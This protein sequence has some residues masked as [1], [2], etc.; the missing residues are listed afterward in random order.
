MS[1]TKI[2]DS[3]IADLKVS[4][5]PTRPTA[6]TAFGGRG[7]TASEMKAAFDR[8]PLYIIERLNELWD[9]IS[10]ESPTES[11]AD[12]IYTNIKYGHTLR[13]LFNDITSGECSRYLRVNGNKLSAELSNMT[14]RISDITERLTAVEKPL[15]NVALDA[16]RPY[17][18]KGEE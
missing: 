2:S 6:P 11:V 4:A 16:G 5:L 10:S 1:F 12:D 8:L 18:P 7:Y 3:E 15:E 13:D 14:V 17:V 9:Y